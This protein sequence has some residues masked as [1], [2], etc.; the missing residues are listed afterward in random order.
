MP[1]GPND[2]GAE[3]TN[4]PPPPPP[5]PPP[6][7]A[8][9]ILRKPVEEHEAEAKK[10]P[11]EGADG[12]GGD[13]LFT[14]S[15]RVVLLAIVVY[16]WLEC[17][18][19]GKDVQ[20]VSLADAAYYG[21]GKGGSSG[22]GL[23]VFTSAE[24][25]TKKGSRKGKDGG[26]GGGGGGGEGGGEGDE[27][28]IYLS[29]FGDVFDVSSGAQYYGEDG[30]YG[31]FAGRDCSKAFVTGDFDAAGLTDDVSELTDGQMLEVDRWQRFYHDHKTYRFLG[32]LQG[33]FYGSDGR[34][35]AAY[36]DAVAKVARARATKVQDDAKQQQFPNCNMKW[37]Q[38]VGGELWCEDP[39]QVP[40]KMKHGETKRCAC[41]EPAEAASAD[42]ALELEL[43]DG[44]DAKATKCTTPP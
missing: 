41:F 7:T 29:I 44:C 9:S 33:Q 38:N 16:C 6:P 30:G 26:G 28:E 35:T 34:P 32:V 1:A 21:V 13:A 37:A 36:K 42:K 18:K 17:P 23:R 11:A 43:Y 20:L 2:E 14:W 3:A 5:P 8:E 31:F 22:G 25:A 15:A 10:C 19:M 40:R 27:G 12:N 39:R 4:S 24:L